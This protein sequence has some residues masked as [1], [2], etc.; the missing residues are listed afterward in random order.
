MNDSVARTAECNQVGRVV[1]VLRLIDVMRDQPAFSDRRG[2]ALLTRVPVAFA[3]ALAQRAGKT[4]C[5]G[6]ERSAVLPLRILLA[7]QPRTRMIGSRLSR[8]P[9]TSFRAERMGP[10]RGRRTPHVLTAGFARKPLAD[11][12]LR[13][14]PDLE[15]PSAFLITD[16]PLGLGN[17]RG[18]PLNRLSAL[19]AGRKAGFSA[20]SI[21]DDVPFSQLSHTSRTAGDRFILGRTAGLDGHRRVAH[22]AREIDRTRAITIMAGVPAE[23]SRIHRNAAGKSFE[24][25]PA[26]STRNLHLTPPFDH[27]S[28]DDMSDATGGNEYAC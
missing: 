13:T 23:L 7:N 10:L 27:Y 8:S 16:R 12:F 15:Q 9:G 21:G 19:S 1:I 11:E 3:D 25:K 14:R 5:V 4:E 18:L 26:V 6:Q 17:L 28:T 20:T 2:A 24:F 22:R